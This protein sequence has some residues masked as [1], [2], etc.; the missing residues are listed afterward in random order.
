[1]AADR[2]GSADYNIGAAEFGTMRETLQGLIAHAGTASRIVS[3]PMAPAA[4]LTRLAGRL[5]VSPLGPYHAL[6]YGRPLWSDISRARRELNFRPRFCN[7]QMLCQ[8]Y[9]WYLNREAILQRTGP[10]SFDGGQAARPSVAASHA[11][12]ACPW[13]S[14]WSSWAR[15]WCRSSR[16]ASRS[17]CPAPP[18]FHG[19]G[20]I[21][22]R[23]KLPRL[24]L[25]L[26]R[27]SAIIARC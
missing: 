24:L 27:R 3:L 20:S 5:G 15:R 1:M 2:P 25:R 17:R 23:A 26:F 22:N 21:R 4:M 7:V 19:S 16:L 6:M 9:D 10:A 11:G 14:S 18:R 8:S 13:S 12:V